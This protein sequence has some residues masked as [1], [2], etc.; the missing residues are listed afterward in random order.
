MIPLCTDFTTNEEF[1]WSIV[2]SCVTFLY[3]NSLVVNTKYNNDI[4]AWLP[5]SKNYFVRCLLT[6]TWLKIVVWCLI[7]TNTFSIGREIPAVDMYPALHQTVTSGSSTLLQCRV[8]SGYPQP[9]LWWTRSNGRQLS[10]NIE[11]LSGG[12]LRYAK[13]FTLQPFVVKSK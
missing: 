6:V 7:V 1:V 2:V 3:F 5:C 4:W 12:V 11:E 9:K 10:R 13:I 8:T